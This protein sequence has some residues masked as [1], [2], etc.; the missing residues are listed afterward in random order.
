VAFGGAV[1]WQWLGDCGAVGKK[2]KEEE[3]EGEDEEE[4]D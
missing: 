2:W 4:E 1:R 3:G